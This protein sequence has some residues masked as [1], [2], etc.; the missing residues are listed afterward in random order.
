MSL[1]RDFSLVIF[2]SFCLTLFCLVWIISSLCSLLPSLPPGCFTFYAGFDRNFS[3]KINP[4]ISTKCMSLN[5][6]HYYLFSK[7]LICHP[8]LW[9]PA[10]PTFFYRFYLCQKIL[11]VYDIKAP[12]EVVV[13]HSV[14][15]YLICFEA[16]DCLQ[17]ILNFMS[18]L[19]VLLLTWSISL[20]MR[21]MCQMLLGICRLLFYKSVPDCFLGIVNFLCSYLQCGKIDFEDTSANTFCKGR[22]TAKV[23]KCWW[24]EINT[25]T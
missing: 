12:W 1:W 10:N 19:A 13:F 7:I 21:L 2:F 9:N 8:C 24:V 17:V 16:F 15:K 25:I 22:R 20:W 18:K 14:V 23:L 3:I 4:F 11:F 5:F 6:P